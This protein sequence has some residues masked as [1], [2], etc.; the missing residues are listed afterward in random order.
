MTSA[1]TPLNMNAHMRSP[2]A[3]VRPVTLAR[4]P[5]ARVLYIA[6]GLLTAGGALLTTPND[7]FASAPDG[8]GTMFTTTSYVSLGSTGN[9]ITF[10]YTAA[11][12]GTSSGAVT[13]TIPS[14]WSAPSTTG[15]TSGYTQASV[16]TVSVAGQVITDSGL[17]LTA[18]ATTIIT[19]GS[20]S[21][22]GPG[23][24]A[25]TTAALATWSAQERSTS[26][27]TLTNLA[28]SPSLT[29]QAAPTALT[30]WS[31][32][33]RTGD[34]SNSAPAA[35]SAVVGD[36]N[37]V[38]G[39]LYKSA[40]DIQVP[41]RGPDLSVLRAYNSPQQT[42]QTGNELNSVACT[43]SSNCWAVG[44]YYNA[45]S[46]DQ[47]LIEQY[48]GTAWNTI[49]APSTSS[50]MNNLLAGVTC[51]TASDCWAVGYALAPGGSYQTLIEQYNGA[52]WSIVTSPDAGTSTNNYLGGI[53]CTSAS[54]C[55]AA[56]YYYSTSAGHDQ[57]LIET[58]N[59]TTW[60]IATSPNANLSQ[61][62]LLKAISCTSASNCWADG[63][64]VNASGIDQ[65]LIEQYDGTSWSVAASPNQGT[66]QSN[67]LVGLTCVSS[68]N[69]WAVGSDTPGI[70]DQTLI[71]EYSG[72]TWSIVTSPNTSTSQANDLTAVTCTSSSNC[73]SVGHYSGT[74]EQTVIDY[75]NGTSWSLAT[76]ANTST[77]QDN[78][79]RAAACTSSADCWAIGG[80]FPT[81]EQTLVEHYNATSW[82]IPSGSQTPLGG[83]PNEWASAAI[84]GM[85]GYGW[86]SNVAMSLS[87]NAGH[88]AVTITD[89]T[90]TA[91]TFTGAG[92]V[93]SAPAYNAA[94][95]TTAAGNWSYTRWN[96]DVFAFNSSGQLTSETDRQG[97]AA[98]F[99]YTSG[100]LSTITDSSSRTLTVTWTGNNVTQI[101]DPDNQTVSYSYDPSG[102]LVKV[103][104]LAANYLYYA[105]DG[106]HDL[107]SVT[108]QNGDVT[109]YTYSAAGQIVTQT[110]PLSRQTTYAYSI[111]VATESATLI[112]DP[113]GDKTQLT[114]DYALLIHRVAAYGTG[115]AATTSYAYDPSTLGTVSQ[116]SPTATGTANSYDGNAN[117]LSALV[118]PVAGATATTTATYNGMN[119]PL[120][121]TDA[122]GNVTTS[123]YDSSGNLCWT[124]AGTSANA[125]STPPTGAA[126]Y[127]YG[128]SGNPGLPTSVTDQDGHATS[129]TYDSHGD[130]AT[131]TNA[132]GDETIN[133]HDL[134]SRKL[135]AVPPAGNVGGC[136]CAAANTTTTTYSA[137]NLVL[138]TTAPNGTGG[139]N[140]TTNTYDNDGNLLTT[141][142]PTSRWTT[143]AYDAA[144]E[145]CWT[146]TAASA[147]AN[148]CGTIPVGATSHT[149]DADGNVHTTTDA[150]GNVTQ[151]AYN[152]LN[153]KVSADQTSALG[154]TTSY[155]YDSSGNVLSTVSPDGNV[156]GC[157]CASSYTTAYTYD[158]YN[159]LLTTSDP[160]G[161][162]TTRTYDRNGNVLTTTD[163]L[164][165]AT[166][167]A[168]DA[169]NRPCWTYADTSSHA[170]SSPPSGAT[171][172]KTYDAAGNVLTVTDGNGGVTT[173]A[174]NSAN[175]LCWSD[176]GASSAG[177]SAPPA[178]ATV[179]TYDVNG[180]LLTTVEPS[181]AI[182]TNTY[183]ANNAMCWSYAGT[184]SNACSSPPAGAN[185]FTYD[186][187]GDRLTMTDGTGT[188]TWTYNS[189]GQEATYT[190]GAGKEIQY[191]PD[192]NGN[193]TKTTY[194]DGRVISQAFNAANEACWTYVGT[195]SS[196]CAS[197]PAGATKYTYDASGDLTA[198]ALPNGVV[199]GYTFD[200][201]N[202]VMAISDTRGT[203][204]VFAAAYTRNDANLLR[205]DT[206]QPVGTSFYH[207][208]SREQVCYAGS[209]YA[210]V[211]SSPPSGAD[212][213]K[214]DA[215][216]N[217]TQ[218][219]ASAQ[220]FSVAAGK[221]DELCW[222]L[223]GTSSNACSSPPTG[224][225]TYSFN[226]NGDRTAATP[227]TGSATAFSYNAL[228]QLTQ[229]QLGSG[230]AT[231][232]AYDG[233]GLRMSKAT[234]S[235]TTAFNW[236]DAGDLPLLLQET[237]GGSTT[238]YV[239]GPTGTL[240]E[241]ILPSGNQYF[242]S[243][244]VLGSTRVLTDSTGAVT[245]TDTYDPY[246]N[247]T[248]STGSV[249]SNLLY[250]GQ[251]VDSESG[252]YYLRA[253]Y[254]D[255]T[256]AQ[257]LTIDPMVAETMSPYA[258]TAGDPINAADPSGQ[259]EWGW[260]VGLGNLT[261]YQYNYTETLG[262]YW[263]LKLPGYSVYASRPYI[264][265]YLE[266]HLSKIFPFGTGGCTTIYMLEKCTFNPAFLI[267]D[268]LQVS[269]MWS[270]GF[271]LTVT[272]GS[273][274]TGSTVQFNIDAAGSWV[275]ITEYAYAPHAYWPE[276]WAVLYGKAA[277][278][279]WIS[280]AHNLSSALGGGY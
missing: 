64:Y 57:T 109:T 228:N 227:S 196:G 170:C 94:I 269:S 230:G 212:V 21:A 172:I 120:V 219:R 193:Q 182:V 197:P 43:S 113:N 150:G 168:Y 203:A 68:S 259:R 95:L 187:N 26:A 204:T 34:S 192:A 5:W 137:L 24:T 20:A 180:N 148:P 217:L 189:L 255:P 250:A 25:P 233:R 215:A 112:T 222:S 83:S 252:L 161:N 279:S 47:A 51:V 37:G 202:N 61:D 169:Q 166:T 54:S 114:Y 93:W 63:Y 234:A 23:A 251:Y 277:R 178:G 229:F 56:G 220:R 152:A 160:N 115:L 165:N 40:A 6:L 50:T 130:L 211:C 174:Y 119:E 263:N 188:S 1:R 125:C 4:P 14:G 147:S 46:S 242:Y 92:S 98:T 163:P 164:G 48:I 33:T 216:G 116:T 70:Y 199:N 49:P 156:S 10:V 80:Y 87:E 191:A 167:N 138:T 145:V 66:S 223:T 129:M 36:V 266:T 100:L 154:A 27:G 53:A 261:G 17:T 134:L 35:P 132:A 267:S 11:T 31:S 245:N 235:V 15:S 247:L 44:D 78:G 265:T 274:G 149:Y 249:Q 41:G 140:V 198:E 238:D 2:A 8:S 276:T 73:W 107:V 231:T 136:G 96:G 72:A 207:Y 272:G 151:Y 210:S 271:R 179:Y 268:P 144:S 91:V 99:A 123:T 226:A 183:N 122:M 30:T 264:A 184:S 176:L 62:N 71:E 177:C 97:N 81:A 280:M 74:H 106:N 86:A 194:A 85:F 209:S 28:A 200:G 42:A 52:S 175:Q 254:Y 236:S 128:D 158:G 55:S 214:Y 186:G 258:Y 39:A 45:N 262:L 18:G 124:V 67:V 221:A 275:N 79:L 208:T 65:T 218:N 127:V 118:T 102:D 19:Y 126:A 101:K 90:G 201:T 185:T 89:E 12:G 278:S 121:Q 7:V 77:S 240:I 260:E 181:G 76:S 256:T 171:A 133:G 257:F 143:T 58:Y 232:Y 59:G 213:Y 111:P 135:T 142:D 131:S 60:S 205:G 75:F 108:D 253:R 117:L 22:G 103:S 173:D 244:D 195:S 241:E 225:T 105:Y 246:G 159:R 157:G 110:A 224:A 270:T 243:H 146:L 82:A 13:V 273:L 9:T 190:N 248:A 155:T 162:V 84:D 29:V 153:Q 139:W 239:Y 3:H 16:G 32:A 141:E 206:S 38:S 69:C 237:T 88:T 104:D